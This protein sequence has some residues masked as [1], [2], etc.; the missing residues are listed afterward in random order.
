[1]KF[2]VGTASADI[3]PPLELGLLTSSVK[4]SYAPFLSVRSPLKAKVVVIKYLG[5]AV[6]LVSLDL[7]GLTETVVG[8]WKH[9]KAPINEALPGGTV[10]ITCTHTHGSPE[11][12][13]LSPLYKLP[14]FKSW[15]ADV[16]NALIAAIARASAFVRPCS[17]HFA[18]SSLQG[19]SLQRRI[20]DNGQVVLSDGLQP[21]GN[22]LMGRQPVDRR[23]RTI[24]FIDEQANAV[25]TVVHNACHPVH[26]M[27]LPYVSADFPG[28]LCAALETTGE[29]EMALFLNGAAG[30]VNPPTVSMGAA[31]AVAHGKALA[32]V[33][34]QAIQME[35]PL[36]GTLVCRSRE[37]SLPV[38]EGADWLSSSTVDAYL[39]VLILGPLAIVFLPGEPFTDVSDAIEHSSP[40]EL[41]VVVGY[42][43]SSV[44]YLPTESAFDE[45]GYETETGRW[46]YLA[47]AATAIVQ[48]ESTALLE[49]S[50]HLV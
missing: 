36:D 5:T 33:T 43:E 9:F 23:V 49:E 41:T 8:D 21:I 19:Y 47:P 34:R 37:I 14:R 45:G 50:I 16:R 17:A 24:R 20:V 28:D 12:V 25:A 10:I 30:D 46:S 4:G 3:T 6:A 35:R 7:L 27:C 48:R 31:Y 38:R 44:G 39:H 1:M 18:A 11:S 22:D 26:E 42:G 32:E 29:T 40:Y 15:L 13:G 2:E